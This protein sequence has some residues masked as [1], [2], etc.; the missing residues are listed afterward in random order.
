MA[1]RFIVRNNGQPMHDAPITPLHGS[2][3]LSPFVTLEA[4]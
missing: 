1:Y 2:S 4:R 3:T